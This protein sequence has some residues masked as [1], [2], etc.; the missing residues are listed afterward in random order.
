MSCGNKV[1]R[2]GTNQ[3]ERLLKALEPDFFQLDER[4]EEYILNY[5]YQLAKHIKYINVNT[6]QIEGNWQPFF[7]EPQNIE[8]FLKNFDLRQNNPSSLSLFVIF[9]RLFKFYQNDINSLTEKQVEYYYKEILSFTPRDIEPD[10]VHLVFELAKN[11]DS[12]KLPK[13]TLLSAGKDENNNSIYFFTNREIVL[14]QISIGELKSIFV[15]RNDYSRIYA[16][17]FANSLDGLGKPL[18][19]ENP[20]W[21][22][23]GKSQKGIPSEFRTMIEPEIGFVFSSP[24]LLLKEGSRDITFRFRLNQNLTNPIDQTLT[25]AFHIYFTSAKAWHGPYE[26]TARVLT[27]TDADLSLYQELTFDLH[28]DHN[29]PPIDIP[30]EHFSKNFPESPFPLVKVLF[31]P[32]VNKYAYDTLSS[33]Q[34]NELTIKVIVSGVQDLV[35]QNDQAVLNA[36]KPFLPFGPQPNIGSNFYIGSKEI[37]SK[38][39]D[40]L[41]IHIQWHD[42]PDNDLGVHYYPYV[43]QAAKAYETA[44]IDGDTEVDAINEA[45][46][47]LDNQVGQFNNVF[48]AN[49]ALLQNLAWEPISQNQLLF[50]SQSIDVKTLTINSLSNQRVVS[51]LEKNE[52]SNQTASG[53]LRI[54][55]SQPVTFLRA[56]GHSD[57]A[58]LLTKVAMLRATN[59][60]SEIPFPKLPYTPSIAS[61]TID[62]ISEETINLKSENGIEKLFHIEPFG[63]KEIEFGINNYLF[64]QFPEE[65]Y[66]YIGLK[67][68]NAPQNISM[69]FQIAEGSGDLEVELTTDD[70]KW[71]YFSEDNWIRLNN[72]QVLSD[73]TQGFQTSGIIILS[74]PQDIYNN[75]NRLPRECDWIRA[76]LSKNVQGVNQIIDVITQAVTSERQINSSLSLDNQEIINNLILKEDSITNLKNPVPAIKK[77]VQ[78]FISFGGKIKEDSLSFNKRVSERLRHKKRAVSVWDYEHLVLEEF[79]EVFKCKCLQHANKTSDFAPGNITILVIS[80]LLNKNAIDPLRP[81]TSSIDLLRIKEFLQKFTSPFVNLHVQNPNYEEIKVECKVGFLPGLDKGFYANLL[82]D[83]IIAFLS[84]WAFEKGKDIVIGGRIHRAEIL[85]FIEN[86]SYVDFITDFNLYHIS[87]GNSCGGISD[88]EIDLDFEIAAPPEIGIGQMEIG[89]NLIVGEPIEIAFSSTPRSVLVSARS[90]AITPLEP[91]EYK[92]QALEFEG[93]GFMAVGVDFEVFGV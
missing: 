66:F 54:N 92:C 60:G 59:P 87:S 55:L 46:T 38:T 93:I 8:S 24:I 75:S 88:M 36:N 57:Y 91:G 76:V 16:A 12:F 64:P 51:M 6:N 13:E 32:T 1:I 11:H 49:I 17:P 39:L 62:Y 18:L 50:A 74:L 41:D 28:L 31:N 63:H 48:Q 73:S 70:V 47:E 77:I 3:A 56:F 4:S 26:T 71:E 27:Q 61:L 25:N 5:I 72:E 52:L 84:P 42:L 79:P 7:P 67:G 89:N 78:P 34:P 69:F 22:P 80:N 68:V 85:A 23:F 20:R 58:P 14:N 86:L 65:A 35:I 29:M 2:D 81:L 33:I 21:L 82:N 15:D 10:K 9:L 40:T 45:L 53:F 19:K 90:H 44:I 30:K 43:P 83:E 37:F